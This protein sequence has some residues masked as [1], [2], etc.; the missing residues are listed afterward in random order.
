MPLATSRVGM[1]C[2]LLQQENEVK[3]Q[4]CTEKSS[5][6]FAAVL[7]IPVGL[8]LLSR[9]APK[10]LEQSRTPLISTV[11]TEENRD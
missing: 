11:N 8:S 5:K 2:S 1:M 3:G 6:T 4:S 9:A 7:F 10:T